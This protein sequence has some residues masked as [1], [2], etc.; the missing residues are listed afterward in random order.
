M[1]NNWKKNTIYISIMQLSLL[2]VNLF[3]ITI[4]SREYGAETYGEYASS[5]SLSVLIGTAAVMSLA[6]VVTKVLA[7]KNENSKLMF[8]N[9]YSLIIRNLM[10]ALIILIPLTLLLNRDLPMTILFLVGFVFNEMIH[11]ALAYYQAKGDFVTSSKQIILRTIV[12]GVGAWVL[13]LQ[14]FTITSLIIFQVMTLVAFFV[15]AHLSVP[16]NDIEL[17]SNTT[18]KNKLQESGKKMVLTT[19]SSALISELDIVLLGLFYS[20]STL[21]VLA[22]SRRILEIIFQLVAASLDI[23]FPEL[24]KAKNRDSISELRI[25]LRKVFLLSFTVPI[26]FIFFKGLASEI[27]TS[28]LGEE[29]SEVSTY[30]SWI[31]FALPVMVWSRINI[32]FSRALNFEINITKSILF[33]SVAS[34]GI[35]YFVHSFNNNP[36]VLSIILSQIVI[37]AITTYSF[38]KSYE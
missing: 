30:T 34:I 21:G 20:G 11:V 8:Q 17:T 4:I 15:V 10:I 13:V 16:K 29:F 22:W 2:L 37:G 14:G 5:K 1:I 18:V 6:L 25:K 19:F 31:L 38:K 12:Y 24:A 32:I 23:L 26:L 3:L 27:F 7:Q 36:A 33:G 28:L 9:A 35:Y